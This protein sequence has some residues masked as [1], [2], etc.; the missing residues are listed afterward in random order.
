[1]TNDQKLALRFAVADLI[2]AIQVEEVQDPFVRF[3][4]EAAMDTIRTLINQF[5]ECEDLQEMLDAFEAGQDAR[6]GR[7]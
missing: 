2:G 4:T 7:I 6:H 3:D 5:P 1:M